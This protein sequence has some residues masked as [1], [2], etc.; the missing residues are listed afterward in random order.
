LIAGWRHGL[1]WAEAGR[2][3]ALAATYAIE[4]VGT[5][6]HRYTIAEFAARYEQAFGT[7][8]EIE[9]FFH[10]LSQPVADQAGRD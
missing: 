10:Q 6:Q 3:G 9:T 2:L 5:Q 4:H 8:A 7:N 1:G